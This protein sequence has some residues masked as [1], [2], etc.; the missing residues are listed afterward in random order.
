MTQLTP[1]FSLEELTATA[2]R[3]IDNTPPAP[4]LP[5]LQTLAEGLEQVR[6][7]LGHPLHINSGYRSPALNSEV[8]GAKNSAHM[9]GYAADFICPAF[10]DPLAICKAIAASQIQFNQIIQEGT[11][12]HLSFAPPLTRRSILTKAPGGGYREGL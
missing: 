6:A 2:H 4:I 12:T 9:S 10:G 7:L 1:H 5:H 3:G 11:W 8:G